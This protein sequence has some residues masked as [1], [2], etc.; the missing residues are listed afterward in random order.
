MLA[1]IYLDKGAR[2]LRAYA[3]GQLGIRDAVLVEGSGISR[4][5]RIAAA[6]LLKAVAAFAPYRRL[7][8]R[9]DGEIFKTGTLQGIHTRVGYL[10]RPDGA[11]DRFVL[12]LNTPG[13]SP[14]AVM[15]QIKRLLAE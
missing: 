12:L 15:R 2:A 8:R 14:S 4:S 1:H 13:K 3:A 10:E 9:Q 5:N 7:M 6:E 11:P